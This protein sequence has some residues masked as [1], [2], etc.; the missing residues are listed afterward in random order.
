M[1]YFQL[2]ETQRNGLKIGSKWEFVGGHF[3]RNVVVEIIDVRDD[4]LVSYR[5]TPTGIA[6]V[7]F[8][9]S[10]ITFL[11][12]YKPYIEGLTHPLLQ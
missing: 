4:G 1:N 8:S 3:Y 12:G 2:Y 9:L 5:Y 10:K 6:T 11:K 7:T